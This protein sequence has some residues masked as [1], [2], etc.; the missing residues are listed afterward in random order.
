MRELD[1]ITES[2]DTSMANWQKWNLQ[3]KKKKRGMDCISRMK[4][5]VESSVWRH[6]VEAQ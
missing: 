3:K 6:K 5:Q 1:G 2:M 4:M